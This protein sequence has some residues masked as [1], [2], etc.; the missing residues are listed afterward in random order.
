M[1]LKI[2]PNEHGVI[3][4]KSQ[5]G[6]SY[7]GKYLF[8]AFPRAIFYD[9][10]HDP[11]HAHLLADFPLATTPKALH[12]YL[13][14]GKT[15]IIYRPA[16]AG[17]LDEAIQRHD[18]VCRI[19]YELGNITLF[20]DEAANICTDRRIGQ[21]HYKVLTMGMSRGI[22]LISCT[23]KPVWVSSSILSE[24]KWMIMFQVLVEQHRK[25][26]GGTTGKD[27]AESL[28]HLDQYHFRFWR[29]NGETTEP[30]KLPGPGEED[31]QTSRT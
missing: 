6:K 21:W 9:L 31:G 2:K 5:S 11:A 14:K 17:S 1:R 29:D 28:L 16:P 12:Q 30:L 26:I 19:I 27:V 24:A 7:C 4:G 22:G 13:K 8:R 3:V 25:K 23:Q 18:Q 10:K 20:D 15:H